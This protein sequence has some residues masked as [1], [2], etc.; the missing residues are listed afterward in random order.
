MDFIFSL[1]MGVINSP[2]GA[3]IA[4]N[5]FY[6]LMAFFMF[7]KEFRKQFDKVATELKAIN[8]TISGIRDSHDKRLTDLET[9]VLDLKK[10]GT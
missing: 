2:N 9:D 10:K 5:V 3:K 6:F 7:R 8:T 4:E 1:V